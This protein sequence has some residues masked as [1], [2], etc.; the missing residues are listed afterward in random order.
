MAFDSWTHRATLVLCL[1]S[2]HPYKIVKPMCMY[3]I[4]SYVCQVGH[5]DNTCVGGSGQPC[6]GGSGRP[7]VGGSDQPCMGGSDLPCVGSSGQPCVGSS[8]QPCVVASLILSFIKA[9]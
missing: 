9:L 2:A 1:V 7:C 5:V 3:I 6:M 4:I 8:G